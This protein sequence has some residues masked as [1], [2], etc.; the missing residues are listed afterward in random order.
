MTTKLGASHTRGAIHATGAPGPVVESAADSVP[1]APARSAACGRGA[2]AAPRVEPRARGGACE[3]CRQDARVAA[4][5]GYRGG[6]PVVRHWC[7]ACSDTAARQA[8][9]AAHGR[10]TARGRS[11]AL[12]ASYFGLLVG[13]LSLAGDHLGI[14]GQSGFGHYQQIGVVLGALCMALGALARVELVVVA[15]TVVF[16]AALLGDALGLRGGAGFGWKQELGVVV[17]VILS[18]VAVVLQARRLYRRTPALN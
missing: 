8:A 9:D 3:I 4:L 17:A 5:L 13:F 6:S 11:A 10:R 7:L 16:C 1:V 12:L 15:G 2:D 14:T 18:A